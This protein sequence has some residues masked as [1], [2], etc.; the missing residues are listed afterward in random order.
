VR[1]DA[2]L[3]AVEAGHQLCGE[4]EV[5]VAG[6]VG[7]AELE[8]LGLGVRTGDRDTDRRGAVTGRVDQ[9]DRSFEARNQAVV[10]VDRRVGEREDGR[11]VLEQATDVPAGDVGQPA[12]AGLVVEQRLA[13]C[14]E[15]LV[16][17]HAGSVVAEERLG[18]ERGRLAPLVCRVLDDVLE[19]QQVVGGVHHGVELVVD[20]ALAACAD[21]VVAALEDEAGVHQLEADVVAHVGVLVDRADREVAALERGLVG[22]VAALF[23]A[24][25]VPG[26][27]AGVHRVEAGV[28]VDLV[29][30]VVEDVELGF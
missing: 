28:L 29:A 10:R 1:F 11:C 30:H 13:V 7:G 9:V 20:L 15:G 5:R 14:P 23:L 21:L 26:A 3:D 22:E 19:L 27:L 25:G 16:G 24:A 12:V 4:R 8:A 6:S 18:H 17:V 2:V